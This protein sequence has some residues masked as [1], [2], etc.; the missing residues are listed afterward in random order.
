MPDRFIYLGGGLGY[1]EDGP[2]ALWDR[3]PFSVRVLRQ[4]RKTGGGGPCF[5]EHFLWVLLAEKRGG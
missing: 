3:A 1:S 5:G 2:R 4:M